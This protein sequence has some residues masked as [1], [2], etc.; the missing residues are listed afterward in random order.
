[1]FDDKNLELAR[2]F[3]PPFL[4]PASVQLS[5]AAIQPPWAGKWNHF[6]CIV[7]TSHLYATALPYFRQSPLS[8]FPHLHPSFSPPSIFTRLFEEMLSDVF[9]LTL[10]SVSFYYL[11]I[12]PLPSLP[13]QLVSGTFFFF[14]S[15]SDNQLDLVRRWVKPCSKFYHYPFQVCLSLSSWRFFFFFFFFFP[16]VALRLSLSP[17]HSLY[18]PLLLFFIMRISGITLY[19]PPFF[20]LFSS[21]NFLS[22]FV[23]RIQSLSPSSTVW[24]YSIVSV[25]IR[26]FR[27]RPRRHQ[28]VPK[29]GGC[30]L[31]SKLRVW[32]GYKWFLPWTKHNFNET[33][34]GI[35]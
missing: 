5:R 6:K 15:D 10:W 31:G 22:P 12:L 3:L 32:L 21:V 11:L 29:C 26:Q 18:F 13:Q 20:C 34:Y 8:I 4:P 17:Q 14:P 25:H 33:F 30:M 1:M 19:L 2:L 16:S 35:K 28:G 9:I 27:S 23:P 24:I 7:L